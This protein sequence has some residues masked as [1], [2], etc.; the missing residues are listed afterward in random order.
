MMPGSPQRLAPISEA[1]VL[2]WLLKAA[3]GD[4]LTYWQGHLARDACALAQRL[5]E[6]ARRR[7]A[8]TARL[9]WKLAADERVHLVQQR[10]GPEACAYLMVARRRPRRSATS[11]SLQ[12][13]AEA[14]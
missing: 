14:A 4:R 11:L 5:P 10:I 6:D 13:L 8:G 12:I 1:E 2:T 9:A 3:A 7:L